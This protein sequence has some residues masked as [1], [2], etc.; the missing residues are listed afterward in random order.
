MTNTGPGYTEHPDHHVTLADHPG[1]HR[2][3]FNGEAVADST[4]TLLMTESGCPRV[5]YFPLADVRMD[6]MRPSERHTH[7][8]FK[9]KA[10]YWHVTVGGKT[11]EHAVWAYR[12][13]YDEVARIGDHVAFDMNRMDEIRFGG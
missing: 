9:G 13:P 10:S 1:R 6:R 7:C 2:V 8:P 12:D 4:R 11:A 3:L 5:H